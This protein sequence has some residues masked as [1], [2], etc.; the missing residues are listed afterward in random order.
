MAEC[1]R[2]FGEW[3]APV[4]LR[5]TT[6]FDAVGGLI[7]LEHRQRTRVRFSLNA[8]QVSR[9]FEGGTASLRQR[10]VALRRMAAAGYPVGLTIAPIMPVEG[11]RDEYSQL[12]QQVAEALRGVGDVNLTAELITHRFTEGSKDVLLQWYPKTTLDLREEAR[13]QKRTKF[14]GFKYV[15]PKDSMGEMKAWFYSEIE[16]TLPQAKVLYWT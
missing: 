12:F 9:D 16:H 15:Y 14:G 7:G 11:W 10:L 3:D 2:F 8:A 1:I 6:K 13:T 5:F 4:Q